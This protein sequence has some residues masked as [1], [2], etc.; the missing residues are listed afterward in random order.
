M[1]TATSSQRLRVEEVLEAFHRA[2]VE[3]TVTIVNDS[4][5]DPL[6][7]GHSIRDLTRVLSVHAAAG[8]MPTLRYTVAGLLEP[9]TAPNGPA[10]RVPSGIGERTPPTVAIDMI[11]ESCLRDHRP[12]LIIL[13]FAEHLLPEDRMHSASGDT[14][15]IVEQIAELASD[16]VWANAG[17]RLVLIGRTAAVDHHVAGLPGV[18]VVEIGLPKTAERR[19]AIELMSNSPR[20]RFVLAP[21]LDLDRAARLTGG[22]S[23]H[24]LSTMRLHTSPTSPLTVED[25]LKRKRAA[26]RQAAGETLIVHDEPLSID[27]DVAGLP[28]V[29][30][31]LGEE[32]RRG[33]F[34]LRLILAGPPG[35]G[36]T[37]VSTAI[38]ATLGVPA[39]ELGHILNRYVGDS[40][41]NLTRALDAI[42]ANAPCLVIL[43]E[44]DETFLGRRGDTPASDGGQ[45]TANLRAA[46]FS[47]L[48]DVGAQDSISVI[49]LTNR[50]DR[51]DEAAT[52]RFVTL[53]VLHPSPWEAAEIMAIQARR[54]GLEFDLD[55]AALALLDAAAAFS[56]RQAVRLLGRAH[57]HAIEHGRQRVDGADVA[58]AI[59]ESMQSL[60]PLEERQSLLA[61]RATSWASHLPWN[62]ARYLGDQTAVVPAY[63]DRVVRD[64]GS[65]DQVALADRI[66]ELELRRAY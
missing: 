28:Q 21:D 9:I 7:D 34:S 42:A 32:M 44:A 58:A 60:G 61:L 16:P 50:P 10:A 54:E 62:A 33:N 30:R 25:I 20:H 36:K 29:R 5:G 38:A 63:L 48:G 35:N 45:V 24:T 43:D 59:G 40:E 66:G 13:D 65:I 46:L 1:S 4:V 49:G 6:V 26:I 39:I 56:G 23:I 31:V 27:A 19:T 55:G 18:N 37:R 8:G 2:R 64:D 53:P 22:M 14:A 11:R 52:D 47:W 57:V 51:L 12:H 17:H 15:R 3:G 41:A